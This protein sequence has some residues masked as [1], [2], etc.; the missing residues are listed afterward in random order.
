MITIRP[1]IDH[2][3]DLQKA[4]T[5]GI[6]SAERDSLVW[7][8]AFTL[9]NVLD[10]IRGEVNPRKVVKDKLP[11]PKIDDKPL[12]EKKPLETIPDDKKPTEKKSSPPKEDGEKPGK[13]KE[14][15][16]KL[17]DDAGE[18]KLPFPRREEK[19]PGEK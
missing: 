8:R 14:E 15:G 4:I 7:R 12:T 3:P 10:K 1:L 19:K 13:M 5:A 18:D 16:K 2:R 11:P 6:V 9:R 17:G